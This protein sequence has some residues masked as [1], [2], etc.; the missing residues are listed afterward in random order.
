MVKCGWSVKADTVCEHLLLVL[1]VLP[2]TLAGAHFLLGHLLA[3]LFQ[4]FV[5]ICFKL[6]SLRF[7]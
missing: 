2:C 7:R 1:S 3:W 5:Q 4:I 6:V